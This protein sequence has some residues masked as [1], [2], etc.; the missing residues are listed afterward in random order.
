MD[1]EIDMLY[2]FGDSTS[3]GWGY[4]EKGMN[5]EDAKKLSWPTFLAEHLNQQLIDYSWPGGSNWRIARKLQGLELKPDDIVIIQWSSPYRLE[6]GVSKD[7]EY[8]STTEN[9]QYKLVDCFEQDEWYRTK[10]MCQSLIDKTTDPTCRQLMETLFTSF[11]NFGWYNEMFKVMMSSAVYTLNKSNCKYLMFDGW[12]P[13][14]HDHE[15]TEVK[16]YIFRG[17]TWA[18]LARGIPGNQCPNKS[19]PTENENRFLAE[20]LDKKIK[21]LYYSYNEF[22]ET[23]IPELLEKY[24]LPNPP[25]SKVDIS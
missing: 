1:L 5:V 22:D 8:C 24:S 16:Q 9:H 6:L 2:T 18:N 11:Y 15:F 25:A 3:F 20:V 17:S 23:Y 7:T 14:C 4:M 13:S 10:T 12:M 21:E 19:Y